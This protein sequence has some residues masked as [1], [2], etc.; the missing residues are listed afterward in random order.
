[1][2]RICLIL[3]LK[4]D[5]NIDFFMSKVTHVDIKDGDSIVVKIIKEKLN[6]NNGR[7][8]IRLYQGDSCDI[9]FDENGKGLVSPKILIY[10]FEKH[11]Y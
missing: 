7:A 10:T 9:W 11:K 3:Q 6:A 1:M 5:E 4:R 2:K 8:T